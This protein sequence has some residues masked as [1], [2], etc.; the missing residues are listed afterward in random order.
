[1]FSV[2]RTGP[3]FIAAGLGIVT[4]VY[5]FDPLFRDMAEQRSSKHTHDKLHALP[6]GSPGMTSGSE[7]NVTEPV[8]SSAFPLESNK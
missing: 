8:S 7:S 5:I 4:G 1:M 2:R 3:Y 6:A